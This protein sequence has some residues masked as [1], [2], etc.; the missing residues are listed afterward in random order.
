[1]SGNRG[2]TLTPATRADSCYMATGS[3]MVCSSQEFLCRMWPDQ[4][5]ERHSSQK[6][7]TGEYFAVIVFGFFY[8]TLLSQLLERWTVGH[9]TYLHGRKRKFPQNSLSYKTRIILPEQLTG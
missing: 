2:K 9:F 1:M 5:V 7:L 8:K 4:A 3:S 6:I